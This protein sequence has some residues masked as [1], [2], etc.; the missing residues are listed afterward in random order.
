MN[1]KTWVINFIDTNGKFNGIEI[2]YSQAPT[3]IDV[4]NYIIEKFK[5]LNIYRITEMFISEE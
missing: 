3:E 1:D 2:P 5:S 4:M